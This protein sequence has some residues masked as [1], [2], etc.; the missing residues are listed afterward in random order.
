MTTSTEAFDRFRAHFFHEA[1]L[2]LD[3]D[4]SHIAFAPDFFAQMEPEIQRALSDMVALERGTIANPDEKR[5]V[6]HYW[7]RAPA[8]APNAELREVIE[9]TTA[10]VI[11]F[12]ADVHEGRVAPASA[13]QFRNVL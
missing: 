8:L 1:E 9:T 4:L 6:G 10:R 2:G 3:L 13:P 5:M 7:L 11:A 12:A